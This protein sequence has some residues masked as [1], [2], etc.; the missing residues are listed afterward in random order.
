MKVDKK[1]AASDKAEKATE[2]KAA[3]AEKK[4]N[5]PAAKRAKKNPVAATEIAV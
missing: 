5:A 2:R 3:V 1:L 4:A